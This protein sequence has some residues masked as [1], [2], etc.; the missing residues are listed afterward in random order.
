ME[1]DPT[2][3]EIN[4]KMGRK[5]RVLHIGNIANNAYNN[6]RI[7]RQCGVD[8][9]VLCHDYYHIMATPEWED[10]ALTTKVDP[11]LPN[12]WASN[13]NG[14]CR[15]DWYV[16]GPQALCLDYF[17]AYRRGQKLRQW[18]TAI[19]IEDAYLD[20]LRLDAI[21]KRTPWRDPHS[22]WRLCL[23]PLFSAET[24]WHSRSLSRTTHA[25]ASGFAAAG[26]LLAARILARIMYAPLVL[27][28]IPV[29]LRRS[30]LWPLLVAAVAKPSRIKGASLVL[31]THHFACKALGRREQEMLR[32]AHH[33][34]EQLPPEAKFSWLATFT[35]VISLMLQGLLLALFSILFLPLYWLSYLTGHIN[36]PQSVRKRRKLANQ[37]A[38]ALLDGQTGDSSCNSEFKKHIEQYLSF[39][40]LL[41]HYDMIQ[42]YSISGIIPLAN[43][44][45]AFA[46]YEHG[47]L[48]KIPFEDSLTGLI[49][50]V[51]Y[52]NSPAVFVTNTDVLPSVERLGLDP[53]RVH[54]LPHA[55][56]D[57]KLMQWR[58]THPELAPPGEEVVL[59]SPT[60]QHWR[61]TNLSLT[62]GNDIMLRAAG[63]LLADGRRF[64]LI[65]VEWGN[66]VAE[67]KKLI[68]ELGFTEAVQWVLP[69]G[70]QDLWRAYC[71]S[72][73]VLDQFIL[74]A[75]GGVGFETLALGR[76]LI[77][78]TDQPTL[79]RFFGAAPPV[80]PAATIDEVASS[81]AHV[82]DDPADQAGL[83]RAG[84]EWIRTYHSARRTVAIQAQVYSNLLGLA[85]GQIGD[86]A[87]DTPAPER[88]SGSSPMLHTTQ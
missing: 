71:T 72:H 8:A 58:G 37:I 31:S 84:C 36:R 77:T 57:R 76:R 62:K 59:F 67:S 15:P 30:V 63:R 56:D 44:H 1:L 83:G 38:S 52:R 19:A 40:P 46:S 75:L 50:R 32:L 64:Q 87:T 34:A 61:D 43:H 65:M 5:L 53:A 81:L 45:P 3:A 69:M 20:L 73:A 42:G 22:F 86:P 79:A 21:I 27:T 66:D 55:F 14:F 51:A 74:P 9:D 78:R 60:R 25:I 48:R 4:R 35:G 70:K 2:I 68:D 10:G 47:T 17:D 26:K 39:G 13:L 12:W 85:G 16:Q 29:N 6:A 11:N 28:A 18:I 23:A 24:A 33:A 82:L 88:M 41:K 7:Q 80:L 49:C 54:Y